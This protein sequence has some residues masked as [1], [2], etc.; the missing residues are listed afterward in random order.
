M[1]FRAVQ[2][3]RFSDERLFKSDASMIGEEAPLGGW[4]HCTHERPVEV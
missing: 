1:D 3:W 4:R 2:G